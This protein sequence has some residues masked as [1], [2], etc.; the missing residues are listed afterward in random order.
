MRE[1]K[2]HKL[3]NGERIALLGSTEFGVVT[4]EKK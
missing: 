3:K 4:K 2:F 1:L